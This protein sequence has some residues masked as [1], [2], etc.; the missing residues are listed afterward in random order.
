MSRTDQPF[1]AQPTVSHETVFYQPTKVSQEESTQEELLQKASHYQPTKSTRR[2]RSRLEKRGPLA[3][4]PR[5]RGAS[6]TFC[7]LTLSLLLGLFGAVN[8]YAAGESY[9]NITLSGDVKL[10]LARSGTSTSYGESS[11]Q[12]ATVKTNHF[13]GYSFTIAAKDNDTRRLVGTNDNT[14]YLDSITTAMPKADFNSDTYNNKWAFIPDHLHN[15]TTT[16]ENANYQPGPLKTT[17]TVID[18]PTSPNEDGR[19]YKLAIA[20]RVDSTMT[21]DSYGQTFILAATG[22]GYDYHIGY[23]DDQQTLPADQFGNT[24]DN[25]ITLSSVKPTKDGWVFKGWCDQTTT[26]N[27]TTCP[28]TTYQPGA[29]ITL[30][31]T[32]VNSMNLHAIWQKGYDNF[33][34]AFAAAGKQKA[35]DTDYYQMQDMTSEICDSVV[36]GSPATTTDIAKNTLIDTRNSKTYLVAKYADGHCWMRE[37]LNL[38][39]T[40]NEGVIDN[41]VAYDFSTGNTFDY[42]P[43]NATQTSANIAWEQDAHDGTRS[44]KLNEDLCIG[45]TDIN[46]SG[47]SGV[48]CDANKPYEKIGV[49]YNWAAATAQKASDKPQDKTSEVTTSICPK[50]WRLPANSGDY[51]FSVLMG[52]Y[53]LPTTNQ[54]SLTSA[55]NYSGQLQNPLNFNRPGHYN[56][57]NGALNHRGT[58]GWFW[59]SA[60]YSTTHAP[61]FYFHS[62]S[63][64]PQNGNYK[65]YGFSVRCVAV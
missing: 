26:N 65:G 42:T 28:G 57:S 12:T 56:W 29:T 48:T 14:K 24:P 1:G 54:G 11:A 47:G 25:T 52:S 64:Y 34:A 13:T 55:N 18:K 9:I 61:Y 53:G 6:S 33:A 49:L 2:F 37:N 19:E 21:L 62:T 7:G 40:E 59:S 46:T 38:T 3:M 31:G 16:V 41:V 45:G 23:T 63:F 43:D 4:L 51:S 5:P 50:G 22:S 30:D 36:I 32:K 39:F 58:G 15:G 8:T 10:D 27:G 17:P 44:F 35:S 60:A 20:A